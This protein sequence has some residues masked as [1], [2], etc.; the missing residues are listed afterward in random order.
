MFMLLVVP[1]IC[2]AITWVS[3]SDPGF[4]G[5]VSQYEITNDEYK[6]FLN[7]A[8]ASGD[9]TV[10]FLDPIGGGERGKRLK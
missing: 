4:T 6:Q 10:S 3:V 1:S 2:S 5:D 9:I 7:D 8:L